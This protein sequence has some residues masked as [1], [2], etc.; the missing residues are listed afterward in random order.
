MEN[1]NF[2][3]EFIGLQLR[4]LLWYYYWKIHDYMDKSYVMKRNSLRR[5]QEEMPVMWIIILY[6]ERVWSEI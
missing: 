2:Y 4:L 6:R 3:Y 5:L 1:R